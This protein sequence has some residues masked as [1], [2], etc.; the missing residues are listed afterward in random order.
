MNATHPYVV[1]AA[2]SHL[3][4]IGGVLVA[5][6]SAILVSKALVQD[7]RASYF[8]QSVHA[9]AVVSVVS[10]VAVPV[11]SPATLEHDELSPLSCCAVFPGR[12][13]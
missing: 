2:P 5:T 10:P 6:I 3:G 4:F 8:A 7:S 11:E 13:L 1:Q 9:P 12:A